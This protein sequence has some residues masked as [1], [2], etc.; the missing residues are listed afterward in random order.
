MF[1]M[2]TLQ[3]ETI[4]F[5]DNT[6]K[7]LEDVNLQ[8]GYNTTEAKYKETLNILY[9]NGKVDVVKLKEGFYLYI[10]E[11]AELDIN[12]HIKVSEE[13]EGFVDTYISLTKSASKENIVEIPIGVFNVMDNTTICYYKGEFI[14][15]IHGSLKQVLHALSNKLIADKLYLK[16]KGKLVPILDVLKTENF[17]MSVYMSDQLEYL[18]NASCIIAK[19][20]YVKDKTKIGG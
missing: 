18:E 7:K 11:G 9:R 13:V 1:R 12:N 5:L 8:Y 17:K 3:K 6:T 19:V 15:N 16:I 20:Y 14:P 2:N 4:E 10:L